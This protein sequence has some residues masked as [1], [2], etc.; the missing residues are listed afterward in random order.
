MVLVTWACSSTPAAPPKPAPALPPPRADA[1]TH[2]G[3]PLHDGNVVAVVHEL[4]RADAGRLAGLRDAPAMAAHGPALAAAWQAAVAAFAI[5]QQLDPASRQADDEADLHQAVKVLDDQ[6]AAAGLDVQLAIRFHRK[7]DELSGKET[8]TVDQSFRIANVVILTADGL[9]QRVLELGDGD[10][11]GALGLELP[12]I[13]PL[14]NLAAIDH[15]AVTEILPVLAPG[16]PFPVGVAGWRNHGIGLSLSLLAGAAV[17]REL[18]QVLGDDAPAAAQIAFLL[19]ER[20]AL[21]LKWQEVPLQQ[22]GL[23]LPPGLLDHLRRAPTD[24]VARVREIQAELVRLDAGR[25]VSRLAGL[26]TDSVRRHEAEHAA[27]VAHPWRYPDA[28]RE[29]VGDANE[30]TVTFDRAELD[31]YTSQL[32]NDPITPEL[33]LWGVATFAF[34]K[35]PSSPEGRAGTVI[36]RG[37]AAQ[38]G[39]HADRLSDAAAAC[40]TATGDQLRVAARKVWLELYGEPPL[41]IT[42]P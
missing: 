29:L 22:F 24:E 17:R 28:L 33:T 12:D 25:I 39:N 38:L 3:V 21:I 36:L 18:V 31:A 16:A 37:L 10:T 19:Q 8:D 6:L 35:A 30:L 11:R 13:G 41:T 27:D 26:I 42:A 9:R 5:W 14:V 1:Y 15:Y 32:I 7:D 4:A 2:G 40:T 20:D 34:G 23:E